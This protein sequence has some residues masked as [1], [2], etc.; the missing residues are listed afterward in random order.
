MEE[1]LFFIKKTKRQRRHL[2]L[3]TLDGPVLSTSDAA[4]VVSLPAPRLGLPSYQD[5]NT[6]IMQTLFSLIRFPSTSISA[7]PLCWISTT[8]TCNNESMNFDSLLHVSHSRDTESVNDTVSHRY[9]HRRRVHCQW[10]VINPVWASGVRF[11]NCVQSGVISFL[12]YC[13]LSRGSCGWTG[14]CTYALHG[15]FALGNLYQKPS[16]FIDSLLHVP[17]VEI[18]HWKISNTFIILEA[19]PT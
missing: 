5:Y 15:F 13:G 19:L 8:G 3:L 11:G 2:C 9:Q 10:G 18:Q 1:V 16:K 4:G 17:V 12:S 6:Q 7:A 14:R